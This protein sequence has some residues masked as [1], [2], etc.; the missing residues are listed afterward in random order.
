MQHTIP[1]CE[2]RIF[3]ALYARGKTAAAGTVAVYARKNRGKISRLG[4]TTSVKLGCAVKRNAVRRKIRESYRLHEGEFAAGYDIV[5][6]ART[7]A[8][9]SEFKAIE[10]DII[11]VFTQLNL[12]CG[13]KNEKS[14]NKLN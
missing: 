9:G 1:L 4:L 6:V 14:G 2:N 11:K 8:V 12:L 5:I 10:R 7:R 13:E 3:R